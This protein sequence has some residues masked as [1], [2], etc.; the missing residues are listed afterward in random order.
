M[1]DDMEC[2]GGAHAVAAAL[3]SNSRERYGKLLLQNDVSDHFGAALPTDELIRQAQANGAQFKVKLVS[4][5]QLDSRAEYNRGVALEAACVTPRVASLDDAAWSLPPDQVKTIV[6]LDH[7]QDPQNLGTMM[8]TAWF[9]GVDHVVV[10]SSRGSGS[11]TD[12]VARV[13]CGAL[14]YLT[15]ANRL[16]TVKGPMSAFL[17]GLAGRGWQVI[18]TSARGSMQTSELRECLHGVLVMGNEGAGLGDHVMDTC[19]DLVSI[20]CRAPAES[21]KVVDSLNV[22]AA[23]SILVNDLTTTPAAAASA[24]VAAAALPSTTVTP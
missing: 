6:V 16:W 12:T 11:L 7:V 5:R 4:K 18:G 10:S 2:L 1:A 3:L 24:A 15:A 17:A 9:L 23:F 19:S 22:S 13:S 20:P 8:R 14:D 21:F